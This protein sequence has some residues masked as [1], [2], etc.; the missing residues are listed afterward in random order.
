MLVADIG[1]AGTIQRHLS[2][3]LTRPLNGAYFAL[4][5]RAET[6]LSGIGE[7]RARY[8]D[9]RR[10]HGYSAVLAHDL[11]LESV[12]T[13]PHN[14]FAGFAT[15]EGARRPLYAS[16]AASTD[17]SVIEAVHAGAL[18]FVDAALL[19]AGP[20][21]DELEF[22]ANAV[23]IPLECVGSGRWRAPWLAD[24]GVEDTFTGRG[25]I[26]GDERRARP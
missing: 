20:L 26:P 7:A 2:R 11:L 8:F 23:Q 18:A 9:A 17:W 15:R 4:D 6:R 12:L 22:D 3:V 5:D 13:A 1:Y 10:D 21:A 19:A 14:Q 24:I 25:R 16:D